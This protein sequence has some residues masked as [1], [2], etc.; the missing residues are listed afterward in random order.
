M[1][2]LQKFSWSMAMIRKISIYSY[3]Y[4]LFDLAF[5]LSHKCTNSAIAFSRLTLA[6]TSSPVL[7]VSDSYII[8]SCILSLWHSR[9]LQVSRT[10]QQ[11][12]KEPQLQTLTCIIRGNIHGG[13][14]KG[15]EGGRTPNHGHH[16]HSRHEPL[17]AASQNHAHQTC[18]HPH[19]PWR[20]PR[21]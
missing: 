7:S 1:T 11:L 13:K 18:Y 8:L 10:M 20:R 16:Q 2:I 14:C 5:F 19:H 9:S 17:I 15:G 4:Y 6:I 12:H 3:S 21:R